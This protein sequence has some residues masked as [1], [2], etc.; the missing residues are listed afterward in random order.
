MI[1]I[2]LV[3]SA[4]ILAAVFIYYFRPKKQQRTESIYTH[5]LNAMV[6]GDTRTAL[7]HLRN[8]V[9]QDTNH[10]NA[11]LQMGDILRGEDN[12]QAAIKIHQSLTVRPN[13]SN[14]IKRDIHK[15]LALDFK[16]LGHITKAMG[17]AEMVLKLDRKNLWANEFLLKIFE[18]QREWDK[19]MQTTKA[20]QKLKQSRDPSQIARFL[21][22]QGMEKLEKGQLKEAESQFQKAVKTS[23]EFGLPYLRLGDVFAENRDLVKAIENWEKFAL[24]NPEEGRLVYSKIESALF[25][26][27]RFSEVEKFYERIL[28]KDPSNLNALTKLANVLEEKGE[29]NTAL[30]LVEDAL[31]KNG[32]SVHARLMKLKLSLHVSKPHELSN[33]I[34]EVIQLLTIPHE[35]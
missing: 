10:I 20:I 5:A 23:P 35:K 13:L 22:Y 34:D 4:V 30:N 3:A 21:V 24:L 11:Y 18:Q 29:H 25:D 1:W 26:L 7:S 31:S 19:A 28:E 8:V 9:K 14:E 15:S 6:R 32:S 17:E 27:G 12:A 16:Q 33:Q 2:F